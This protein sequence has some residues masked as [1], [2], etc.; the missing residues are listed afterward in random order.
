MELTAMRTPLVWILLKAS[1]VCANLDTWM[2]QLQFPNFR[3]ESVLNQSTN[4]PMARQTAPTTLTVSIELMVTSASAV[5]GSLMHHQMLTSTR[6]EFVTNQS[7][8]NTTDNN[9]VNHNAPKGLGVDQMRN[10]DSTLQVTKCVSVDVEVFNSPTESVKSSLN[11]NKPMSVTVMHSAL[12]P[13]TDQ[14]VNAKQDSWMCPLIRLS[15]QVENVNRSRTNVQMDLM[16]A[17]IKLIVKTHQ[18][19][20]SVLARRIVLMSRRDTTC[21]REESVVLPPTNALTNLSIPVTRMPTA[22]N[23]LMATPANVSPDTWMS[24]P[25]PTFHQDVSALSPLLVQ[26][27]QLI[28]S[29]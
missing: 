16:T 20:T 2:F 6:E 15:S 27:N 23:S 11:V 24:P 18:L 25:M 29:S 13:T 5:Q 4:A 3:E 9:L 8:L 1:N 28:W 17:H 19:D 21:H 10:A 14:S 26:L 22:S 12:I 7:L